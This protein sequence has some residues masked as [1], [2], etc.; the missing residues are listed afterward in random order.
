MDNIFDLLDRLDSVKE[1][2]AQLSERESELDKRRVRLQQYLSHEREELDVGSSI[3]ADAR[4]SLTEEDEELHRQLVRV[5]G[6]QWQLW[7]SAQ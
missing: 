4:R 2:D 6:E 3:V 5:G 7:V 1:R